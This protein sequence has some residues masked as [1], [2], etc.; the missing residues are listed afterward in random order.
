MPSTFRHKTIKHFKI[1]KFVFKN[2]LLSISDSAPAGET[3]EDFLNLLESASPRTQN[4]IVQ[5]DTE[6]LAK[7]E[8]SALSGRQAKRTLRGAQ[9]TDSILAGAK[10]SA[11]SRPNAPVPLVAS[12]NDSG[13]VAEGSGQDAPSAPSAPSQHENEGSGGKDQTPPTPTIPTPKSASS[14]FKLPG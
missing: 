1:G 14:P 4:A 11:P 5:L 6:A 7:L 12:E 2:H 13:G 3:V 9:G 10:G 8:R